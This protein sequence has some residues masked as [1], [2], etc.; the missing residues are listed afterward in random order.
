ML[1]QIPPEAL[2]A[3][4]SGV[5]LVPG[6]LRDQLDGGPQLL[7]FLRH[8]GCV[9]CRET[10]ADLRAIAEDHPRFPPVLF[11]F[12]GSPT[13]GRAFMRRYWPGGVWAGNRRARA[14]GNTQG[15]R[16]GDI[17]M[18]PGCFLVDGPRVLWAHE[19]AHAADQPDFTSIPDQ[20]P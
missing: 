19:Y 13:E 4:V 16:S 9:F 15:K 18:M 20:I 14:K 5:G 6:R 17:W 2:E 3:R 1:T 12:I 7:V 8:F 10:V 11:F